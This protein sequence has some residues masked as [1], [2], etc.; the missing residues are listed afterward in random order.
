M[1]ALEGNSRAALTGMFH[2]YRLHIVANRY[3]EASRLGGL[4][5]ERY[6]RNAYRE[7]ITRANAWLVE[8]TGSSAKGDQK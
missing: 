3:A 8:R 7:P 5:L 4:I 6:P 1:A 2:Q